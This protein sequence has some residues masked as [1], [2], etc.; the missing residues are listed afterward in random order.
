MIFFLRVS[1]IPLASWNKGASNG[2]AQKVR[3]ANRTRL[4]P[5]YPIG[6]QYFNFQAQVF[7]R[8]AARRREWSD[9]D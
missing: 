5:L 4:V 8:Q 9:G 1:G 3:I 7:H 2:G 6:S